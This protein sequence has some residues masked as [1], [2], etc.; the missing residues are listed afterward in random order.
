MYSDNPDPTPADEGPPVPRF[1]HRIRARNERDATVRTAI[2]ATEAAKTDAA[3]VLKTEYQIQQTLPLPTYGRSSRTPAKDLAAPAVVGTP[4]P[5]ANARRPAAKAS[6]KALIKASSRTP[7]KPQAKT[8]S[9]A[10]AENPT[11]SPFAHIFANKG[12]GRA[13]SDS[14]S[15]PVASP[16]GTAST[17]ATET[18]VQT[19]AQALENERVVTRSRRTQ[20]LAL[21]TRQQSSTTGVVA[22]AAAA[23]VVN[24]VSAAPTITTFPSATLVA[25]VVAA[26]TAASVDFAPVEATASPAAAPFVNEA[27]NRATETIDDIAT[28]T[29]LSAITEPVID[30]ISSPYVR[31]ASLEKVLDVNSAAHSPFSTIP[32]LN[33]TDVSINSHVQVSS[34][35]RSS[36]QQQPNQALAL[37]LPGTPSPDLSEGSPEDEEMDEPPGARCGHQNP[38]GGAS[39]DGEDEEMRELVSIRYSPILI[40]G[41]EETRSESLSVREPDMTEVFSKMEQH[42]EQCVTAAIWPQT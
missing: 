30:I 32:K 8:Q 28:T 20:A 34:P 10:A 33:A 17:I 41:D 7:V 12:K 1:S 26:V 13:Q 23:P 37:F 36:A 14:P 19:T 40:A 9:R 15:S 24:A 22:A 4:K 38:E 27:A 31:P 42:V 11:L 5:G 16:S 25:T 6:S 18:S 39:A 3:T 29:L 35:P 21:V 2:Q